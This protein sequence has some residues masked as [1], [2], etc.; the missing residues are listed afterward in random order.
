MPE[1]PAESTGDPRLMGR[2]A[3]DSPTSGTI[4]AQKADSGLA[5]SSTLLAKGAP[6]IP[7]D[8]PA[9]FM[10]RSPRDHRIVNLKTEIKGGAARSGLALRQIRWSPS[11]PR[12]LLRSEPK[13]IS[14]KSGK[15]NTKTLR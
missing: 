7:L 9:S 4:A 8:S 11:K 15:L 12:L 14:S 13:I 1:K 3:P 10:I 6:E 5:H 2:L